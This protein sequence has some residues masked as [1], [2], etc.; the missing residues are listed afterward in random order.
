MQRVTSPR[1]LPIRIAIITGAAAALLAASLFVTNPS[2]SAG[3]CDAYDGENAPTLVS[4]TRFDDR[5]L[6]GGNG[7]DVV[8]GKKGSDVLV[9]GRGPDVLKGG[10]GSDNLRGGQGPDTFICGPGND[11]VHNNRATGADVID[12][13]CE[14]V[15]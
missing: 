12:P 3:R 4:G 2:A 8:R 11:V 10:H 1:I 6:A 15:R 13:S 7:P 9:G 14:V 5:C